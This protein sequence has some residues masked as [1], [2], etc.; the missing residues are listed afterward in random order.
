LIDLSS[1]YNTEVISW[2]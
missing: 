2:E 1:E